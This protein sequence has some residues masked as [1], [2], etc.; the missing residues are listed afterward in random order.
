MQRLAT[1]NLA[2]LID[3]NEVDGIVDGVLL[4]FSVMDGHSLK[5]PL[6]ELDSVSLRTLNDL[7]DKAKSSSPGRL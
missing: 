2:H 4:K 7:S 5:I 1:L 3:G 6:V